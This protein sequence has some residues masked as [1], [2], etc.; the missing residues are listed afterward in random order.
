MMFPKPCQI[1][2]ISILSRII[3]IFIIWAALASVGEAECNSG[4]FNSGVNFCVQS[5]PTSRVLTK[6]VIPWCF[7]SAFLVGTPHFARQYWSVRFQQHGVRYSCHCFIW[8]WLF[9]KCYR[10][11]KIT[12]SCHRE[13]DFPPTQLLFSFFSSL[14]CFVLFFSTCLVHS[15]LSS[16][17]VLKALTSPPRCSLLTCLSSLSDSEESALIT[18]L[19]RMSIWR[20]GL[21]ETTRLC[22]RFDSGS[23]DEKWLLCVCT[24]SRSYN[25]E[26][27][28]FSRAPERLAANFWCFLFCAEAACSYFDAPL[29]RCVF[30][31]VRETSE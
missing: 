20:S 25:S 6:K 17:S 12:S 30:F 24:L 13:P 1:I 28:C 5:F 2:V 26:S 18:D 27:W 14:A 31:S 16:W 9:W 10:T 29:V 23:L 22:L 15:R 7:F 11:P 8:V 21:C 4:C 19:C 3:M